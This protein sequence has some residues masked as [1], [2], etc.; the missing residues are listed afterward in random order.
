MNWL[1]RRW[2][3]LVVVMVI[4]AGAGVIIARQNEAAGETSTTTSIP[5]SPSSATT[6]A[7]GTVALPGGLE[8]GGLPTLVDLGSD[9][10][11]PCQMMAPELEALATEYAG[12]LTVAVIDVYKNGTLANYFRI[13]AIPTQIFLDPQGKELGRHLGFMSKAEM[14]TAWAELGY[15]LK[16]A[17]GDGS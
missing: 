2:Q 16:P 12:V 1:R 14:V 13:Q 17:A 7:S 3:Y 15:E 6:Q 9:S 8:T 4:L 5:T 11:V 10:C